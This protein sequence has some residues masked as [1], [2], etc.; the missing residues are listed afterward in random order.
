MSRSAR[1][2]C[3]LLA[4]FFASAAV[5]VERHPKALRYHSVLV[6][7]PSPGY[8][9]D[10]FYNTW[11]DSGSLDKLR[12]FLARRVEEDKQIADRLLLAF[13]HAKQ[14]NDLKAL[15]QFRT[16]LADDPSHAAAWFFKAEVEART[17]D[18]DTAIADL[19]RARAA[20]PDAK[21]A[22]R[23]AKLQGRLFARNHQPEKAKAV[24]K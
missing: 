2:S 14:G 10:Q 13:F 8:L 22:L 12:E 19:E 5:A 24:W 23:I 20:E 15:E 18:F 16:A 11:L 1:F 3:A 7:R 9:F 4:A 6:K 17:L 21:L